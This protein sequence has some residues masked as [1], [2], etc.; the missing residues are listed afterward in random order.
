MN[1][2]R[3]VFVGAFTGIVMGLFFG[4][5]VMGL[6]WG[7]GSVLGSALVDWAMIKMGFKGL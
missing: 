6:T 5:A 3:A 1:W 7:A 4:D 2:A